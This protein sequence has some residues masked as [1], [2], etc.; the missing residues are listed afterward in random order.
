M[1]RSVGNLQ[2]VDLRLLRV[3]QSVVRH[4]GFTAAHE[5][6]GI[7]PATIS[8]HMSA[9]EA[10]LG[11]RVCHR[12]RGGFRLTE[13]G[14]QVHSAMLD[15]FGA[16]ENFRGAV[17]AAK[18]DIVG[19]VEFGAVDAIYTNRGLRLEKA[20]AGFADLAPQAKLNVHIASPQELLQGLLTGTFHA[21]LTPT[22][23]LPTVL[24]VTPV[25]RE[26]QNLYCGSS[27]QLASAAEES[28][29]AEMLS[30]FPFVGRSYEPNEPICG[31]NFN[32]SS[33]TSHMESAV[34]M[35]LSGKYIGFLPDHYAAEFVTSGL[36][37][38]IGG[39]RM[40]FHDSFSIALPRKHP[41][42]AA[43]HFTEMVIETIS[44][45]VCPST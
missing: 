11:V 43:K 32:W 10:R 39:D 38:A 5:A 25:F 14:K 12:G 30:R 2:D 36:I 40:N 3:F 9:L 20:I 4:G 29:T 26:L 16:I 18:G 44:Q 24:E 45:D 33:E 41:N 8:N 31:V 19:T 35:I 28:I 23:H 6:L 1:R 22:K 21:I 17:G 13:Q 34:L 15:L 37:R 27:H 42:I 7:S